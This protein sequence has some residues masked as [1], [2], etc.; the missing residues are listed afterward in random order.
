GK[1]SIQNTYYVTLSTAIAK[2]NDTSSQ[3]TTAPFSLNQTANAYYTLNEKHI[4]AIY[5][6]HLYQDEDPFYRA[7]QDSIPFRGVFTSI[8]PDNPWNS[9]ADTFDPLMPAERYDINQTKRVKS[10]KLDAKIDH[11]YILNKMSNLNFSVG[12]TVSNQ[13]FNSGI[14]Q[15]L[16]IGSRNT[17]DDADFIND[18]SYTFFDAYLGLFYKVKKGKFTLTPAVTL[19][20]YHLRHS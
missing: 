8:D 1:T 3:K 13:K 16:D 4:F 11:Y 17:F 10:H 9:N 6:Q 20:T 5:A 15:I 12:T 19:H 18:V 14:F 7:I 2:Q